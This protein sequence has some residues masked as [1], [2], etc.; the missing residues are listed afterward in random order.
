MYADIINLPQYLREAAWEGPYMV[1]EWGA[2]GHWEIARTDWGVPIENDSSTK[3]GF[4]LKRFDAAIRSDR[5]QCVGSYVFLW[6]QKQERTPTWYGMFLEGG[7]E[8]A[9]VDVLH[10]IWNGTWPANRS[11][12]VAGAWLDGRTAYQNVHLKPGQ[13]SVARMEA[14]DPDHDA[15]SYRWEVM[16]E[17]KD[18]KWGGDFETKP[19]C[20]PDLISEANKS[21]IAMKAPA[22][23]GAYRLFGYVYDGK[24]HAGH[25]NIPFQVDGPVLPQTARQ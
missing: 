10:Y 20:L 24:G 5:N 19:R 21:E 22:K 14:S 25:I 2:T 8:T 1:T 11:P 12:Q 18:L 6:G 3:A 16:E 7:E 17:S 4:Y 9:T 13:T 23:P 15:L